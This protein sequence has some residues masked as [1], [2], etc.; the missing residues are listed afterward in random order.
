M[1]PAEYFVKPQ[2]K[3]YEFEP[4]H[5]LLNLAEGQNAEVIAKARRVAFSIFGRVVSLNGEPEG[6]IAL[7]AT[8]SKGDGH[9]EDALSEPDGT[10]RFRGLKPKLEYTIT[11]VKTNKEIEKII[12]SEVKVTMTEKDHKMKKAIVAMRSFEVMDLMMKVTE[13][14]PGK[15]VTSITDKPTNIK[16]FMHEVNGPFKYSAKG[17]VGHMIALPTVPKDDKKYTVNVETV[18]DKF[19]PQKRVSTVIRADEYFRY[20]QGVWIFIVSIFTYFFLSFFSDLSA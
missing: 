15:A 7:K 19:A 1:A 9:S 2:L 4:K 11:L 18:P 20:V 10:F 8:S 3:E 13:E 16:I 12:P 14:K 17:L 5:Q 6:G